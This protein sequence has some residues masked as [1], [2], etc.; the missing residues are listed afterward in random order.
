VSDAGWR[1]TVRL[2]AWVAALAILTGITIG[3]L[4]R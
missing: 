4:L 1:P 3:L 2:P